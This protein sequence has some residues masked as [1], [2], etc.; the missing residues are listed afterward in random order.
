MHKILDTIDYACFVDAR[1]LQVEPKL[2]LLP[3]LRQTTE[4]LPATKKSIVAVL[5]SEP[6]V[7]KKSLFR[8]V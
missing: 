3:V 2:E 7:S 1:T 5:D 4:I 6:G 8:Y